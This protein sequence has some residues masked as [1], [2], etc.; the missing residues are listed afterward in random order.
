MISV[1]YLHEGMRAVAGTF[2]RMRDDSSHGDR[3]LHYD[4]RERLSFLSFFSSSSLICVFACSSSSEKSWLLAAAAPAATTQQAMPEVLLQ[5]S[6]SGSNTAPHWS[7][8]SCQHEG[9]CVRAGWETCTA[10]RLTFYHFQKPDS[11]LFS[12]VCSCWD[13]LCGKNFNAACERRRQLER[14]AR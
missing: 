8:G 13:I 3:Q 12:C 6:R 2:R 11:L 14:S 4:L 1:I 7:G 9:L 5:T 10:D